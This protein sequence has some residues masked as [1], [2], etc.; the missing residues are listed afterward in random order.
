M[1]PPA[2]LYALGAIASVQVGATF[3]RQLFAYI[4]PSGAVFLRVAL[5]AVILLAIGRPGRPRLTG[6]Q[7]RSVVVFG[8]VIAGMNLSFYQ[9]IARIPLGVAVTIEFLGPL[10][11]AIA[12]SRKPLDFAWA[13]L[14]AFG[15]AILSLKG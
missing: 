6:A 3:A 8:L 13:A 11:V 15:V 9:A 2:P 12:G 5:G 4:G 7:W 14:A 1:S 10:G